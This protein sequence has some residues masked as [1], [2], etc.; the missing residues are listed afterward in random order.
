MITEWLESWSE[1]FTRNLW[2]VGLDVNTSFNFL[3][4][5]IACCVSIHRYILVPNWE[6]A[7][8]VD[9]YHLIQWNLRIK[10]TSFVENLR[11]SGYFRLFR[12]SYPV[13]RGY[14]VQ[15]LNAMVH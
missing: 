11:L 8:Q 6:L 4:A 2:K 14:F 10:D 3:M 13:V 9:M 12:S 15:S 7:I 1:F 5:L